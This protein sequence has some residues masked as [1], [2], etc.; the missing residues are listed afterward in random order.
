MKKFK[1]LAV[2]DKL[3]VL[4]YNRNSREVGFRTVTY[5][6]FTWAEVGKNNRRLYFREQDEPDLIVDSDLDSRF[7]CATGVSYVA[8]FT[9]LESLDLFL[10]RELEDLAN[11]RD[12]LENIH[13]IAWGKVEKKEPELS[14]LE[15]LCSRGEFLFNPVI[16]ECLI[17]DGMGLAYGADGYSI[18]VEYLDDLRKASEDE[19]KEFLNDCRKNILIEGD[20]TKGLFIISMLQSC[21]YRWDESLGDIFHEQP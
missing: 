13:N 18:A 11:F 14:S 15:D 16:N 4:N 5:S 9:T 12:S 6:G 19:K 20:T 8:Y 2:G 7:T 3:Y 21:G 1:D 17:Y 10:K